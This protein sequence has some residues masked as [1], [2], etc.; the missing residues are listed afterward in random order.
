MQDSQSADT[1]YALTEDRV[2]DTA[3]GPSPAGATGKRRA[4]RAGKRLGGGPG[5][6]MSADYCRPLSEE[7]AGGFPRAF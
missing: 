3:M 1:G 4:G 5:D 7:S 2:H 6:A